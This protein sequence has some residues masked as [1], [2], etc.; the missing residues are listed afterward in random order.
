MKSKLNII[1]VTLLLSVW[2]FSSNAQTTIPKGKAQLIEFYNTNAK[3]T[4]PEGKT[5]IIYNVFSDYV[6]NVKK[7]GK[8]YSD[9]DEIRIFTKSINGKAKTDLANHFYG[10]LLYKSKDGFMNSCFPII[11][12]ENTTF[13]LVITIGQIGDLKLYDKSGYINIIE[14]DN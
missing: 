5:W 8:G 7:E 10:P 2:S 3:F 14:T 9:G 12:P 6:A 13:E 1:V 11:F 4:V